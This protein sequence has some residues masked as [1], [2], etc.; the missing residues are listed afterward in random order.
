MI[1]VSWFIL[2]LLYYCYTKHL[3]V[4]TERELLSTFKSNHSA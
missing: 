4:F 3:S 2:K 1:K